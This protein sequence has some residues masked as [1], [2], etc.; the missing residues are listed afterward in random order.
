MFRIFIILFLTIPLLEIF[1][2]LKVGNLIGAL[3]TV[4]LVVLTAVIGASL[5][6]MQ[7]ISTIQRLQAST[8]RGEPPA[9]PMIEGAFL[10]FAGALL[11]TPG[12]FTDAVGFAI[13][14]PPFR[15]Y[16]AIQILTRGAFMGG[17]AFHSRSHP[18]SQPEQTSS[19]HQ[20]YN[21]EY[22]KLDE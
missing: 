18:H 21:G 4:F 6:R 19:E 15:Q 10:L 9:I 12:F 13:L 1:L 2:L 22:K 17:A 14:F 11:L 7:G 20:T 5:L 16:L 3:W 8:A